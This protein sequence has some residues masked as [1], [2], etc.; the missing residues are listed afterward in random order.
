MQMKTKLMLNLGCGDIIHPDWMNIDM[1]SKNINVLK[2]DITRPLP[3]ESSSADAVYCSHVLEHMEEETTDRVLKEIHRMLKKDG[4]IRI[5]VPDLEAICRNYIKYLEAALAG[6]KDAE[7]KYDYTM[8][9]LYD[10][11]VRKESGG[12]MGRILNEKNFKCPEFIIERGGYA[13]KQQ[14][15]KSPDNRNDVVRI[16]LI[17][18]ISGKIYRIFKNIRMNLTMLYIRLLLGKKFEKYFQEGIF[19]NRGE[20]HQWMYDRFSMTRMLQN[21]GFKNVKICAAGVSDIAGFK[22]YGFEICEGTERKPDSLY[23]EA[24]K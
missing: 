2:Y 12:R 8:L 4:I 22:E 11:T 9:E 24:I 1:N 14:I 21:T 17:S 20:I 6:D 19:R 16:P 13:A 23:I 3:Y 10:Q 5:L 18:R 7:F 15:E